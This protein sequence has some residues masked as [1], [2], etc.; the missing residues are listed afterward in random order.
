MIIIS[1]YTS[2]VNLEAL[3]IVNK[4][5]FEVVGG[6]I[7][8]FSFLNSSLSGATSRFLTFEMGKGDKQRLADTFATALNFHIVI[9]I[10]VFILGETIGLWFLEYKAVVPDDRMFATRVAYQICL[11]S[12]LFS[13]TQ[14]PY[15]ACLI[16]HERM[17]AFAYLTIIDSILRL[18]ICYILFISPFDKLIT[19]AVL[20]MMVG[21]A[22]IMTYR[23]YCIRHFEECKFKIVKDKSILK[24]MFAFSGWDLFGNFAVMGRTQGVSLMLNTFFGPVVNA[25][26]SFSNTIS[27][28]LTGFSNNVFTAVRPPIVKA[29]AQN[30]LERMQNL[31]ALSTK[32]SFALLLILSMPFLFDAQ[33]ILDLWLGTPPEWTGPLCRWEL[34]LNLITTFSLPLMYSILATGKVKRM[35]I[36]NGLIII[37]VL[38]V[39]YVILLFDLNPLIPYV[40]K[41]ILQIFVFAS[42]VYNLKRN[43]PGFD[44]GRF[45]RNAVIPCIITFCIAAL[46]TY[47]VFSI[48]DEEGWLRFLSTCI[49]STFICIVATY[50]VLCDKDMRRK[51]KLKIKRY[52]KL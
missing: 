34:A 27:I 2:R 21:L 50:Y 11:I 12:S 9:A 33:F 22:M 39:S 46:P 35:S 4:G 48:F 3:G 23:L 31:M 16:A 18:I 37:M 42:Y 25:A 20:T 43:M 41:F 38:P 36:M 8:I 45:L 52:V 13:L 40:A 14:V 30:E 44:S 5:L 1:L 24:P 29:Y 15:N 6:T 26:V 7:A 32:F 51:V 17:G 19:Y 28:T 10:I 47:F 49:V